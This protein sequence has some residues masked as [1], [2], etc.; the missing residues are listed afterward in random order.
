MKCTEMNCF[1]I[2]TYL[3]LIKECLVVIPIF[4][5][6]INIDNIIIRCKNDHAWLLVRSKSAAELAQEAIEALVFQ[7]PPLLL[8]GNWKHRR[9]SIWAFPDNKI[10]ILLFYFTTIIETSSWMNYRAYAPEHIS[11]FARYWRLTP[12][13]QSL[14]RVGP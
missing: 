13:G 4:L 11:A 1:K 3:T 8:A 9:A 14:R 10:S 7:S 6:I 2:Y 12:S 5:L